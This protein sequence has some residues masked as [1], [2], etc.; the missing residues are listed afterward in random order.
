MRELGHVFPDRVDF[1]S[2][3]ERVY[4]VCKKCDEQRPIPGIAGD[5]QTR[6]TFR[7]QNQEIEVVGRPANTKHGRDRDHGLEEGVYRTIVAVTCYFW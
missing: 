2:V 7:V 4:G 6:T 1:G 3:D 5:A